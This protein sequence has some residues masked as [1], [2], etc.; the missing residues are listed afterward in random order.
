MG[1]KLGDSF[2]FC[3][4][5]PQAS[6][7]V[8]CL[9]LFQQVV[10]GGRL[11]LL[12]LLL[13]HQM[14]LYFDLVI[15]LIPLFCQDFMASVCSE[16]HI[17]QFWSFQSSYRSDSNSYQFPHFDHYSKGVLNLFDC[18]NNCFLISTFA[19]SPES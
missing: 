6:L 15:S 8:S 9:Y 2:G 3:H 16:F 18:L 7:K 19:K 13:F 14:W 17:Y 12:G 1:E 10:V 5:I 11:F 4:Q